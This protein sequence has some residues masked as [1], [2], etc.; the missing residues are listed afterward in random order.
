MVTYTKPSI[1]TAAN[2]GTGTS[3]RTAWANM[4]TAIDGQAAH[5]SSV[6][7]PHTVTE[8]QVAVAHRAAVR[9]TSPAAA[10]EDD[11]VHVGIGVTITEMRAVHSGTGLS[12]PSVTWTVRH[13]PDRSAAGNEV[14]TGGTTTTSSTTG[15]DVIVFNDA[16]VPADSFLWVELTA[17]SGTTDKFLVVVTYK[18]A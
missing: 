14:V 8:T 12:S 15:D 3:W 11:L 2:D 6:A 7:N 17:E 18:A 9:F 4:N 1:G 10:D 16:T 13:D 5:E